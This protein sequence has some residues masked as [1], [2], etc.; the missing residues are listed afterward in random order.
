MSDYL[1]VYKITLEGGVIKDNAW[2]EGGANIDGT[3]LQVQFSRAV[4][5]VWTKTVELFKKKS[6][7]SNSKGPFF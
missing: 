4:S 6:I 2:V 3:T 1:S 7:T 5:V